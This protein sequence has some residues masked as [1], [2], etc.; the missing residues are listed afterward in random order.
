ML[1]GVAETMGEY[2]KSLGKSYE[3][4]FSDAAVTVELFAT[5]T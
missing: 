5:S 3:N 4:V 1:T 2:L